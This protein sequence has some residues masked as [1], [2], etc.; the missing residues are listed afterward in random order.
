MFVIPVFS[1]IS[2]RF[3][4]NIMVKISILEAFFSLGQMGGS[5]FGGVVYDALGFSATFLFFTIITALDLL[6]VIFKADLSEPV[7]PATG[8]DSALASSSDLSA[9]YHSQLIDLEHPRST[10][11]TEQARP[12]LKQPKYSD[13]VRNVS[14]IF[15]FFLAVVP[16]I[17]MMYLDPT[18]A[19]FLKDK[20]NIDPSII[21]IVFG[22][23][24]I[25][26]GGLCPLG[27]LLIKRV[28]KNLFMIFLGCFFTG[29]FFIFIGPYSSLL[30]GLKKKLWLTVTSNAMIG[31]SNVLLYNPI[32]PEIIRNLN[33]R[34]PN[35]QE[36][37]KTG[38]ASNIYI[39]AQSFGSIL[40]PILG[41][42]LSTSISF[43]KGAG[44]IGLCM[45]LLSLS[46]AISERIWK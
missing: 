23:M 27:G 19:P 21:G 24:P 15:L 33:L 35:V 10:V 29:L 22:V 17:G 12:S 36:D 6:L 5:F 34:Y 45:I 11:S 40:G 4:E 3:K 44:F 14:I 26:Y 2:L 1:Y 42:F 18:L 31:A 32:V 13:L 8:Q 7:A 37:V 38:M 16:T 46:F 41:G 39:F 43:P 25:F 9:Q 30:F 28:N 20:F